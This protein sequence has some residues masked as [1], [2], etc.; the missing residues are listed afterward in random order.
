MS[1]YG[2]F[3]GPYFPAFELNMEI[4]EVDLRTQSK[5]G[6]I[7]T[8]KTPY[9]D[10]FHAV[11]VPVK[12]ILLEQH[13][14]KNEVSI[15][16]FFNKFPADLVTFTGEILNG[17]VHF[18]CS[19]NFMKSTFE[20][21]FTRFFQSDRLYQFSDTSFSSPSILVLIYAYNYITL[22]FCYRR[23]SVAL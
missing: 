17:K 1:K 10:T 21:L 15:K 2:V 14:T 13:C 4:Y 7:Q 9:L 16:D 6:K 3:S 20:M 22:S 18:L 11:Y 8:R 23:R 12:S 19:E 5:C